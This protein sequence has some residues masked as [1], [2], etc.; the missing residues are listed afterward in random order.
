MLDRAGAT[1]AAFRGATLAVLA[2][3]GAAALGL[4]D[5]VGLAPPQAFL[6]A[7][8]AGALAGVL[9]AER[10]LRAAG[11]AVA[12]LLV[13][14]TALPLAPVLARGLVR[15]DRPAADS[16]ATV[17]AVAVLSGAVG[18]DGLV[19]GQ[20]LDRLLAGL[21][22]AQR[23]DRPIVVS[24]IHP[25][26]ARRVSTRADQ[27]RLAALAGLA[28]RLFTVDSVGTTHDEAV[29]MA[30]LAR[31]QGWRRVALV[32]SPAHTRRACATFER[33]GLPVVCT[34]AP[35]R[36]AAWGGPAPLRSS[37]DR[38]R[39]AANWMYETLGWALYWARGWV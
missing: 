16:G 35:A 8:A 10:A 4:P 23:T 17:D 32:T 31:A 18:D 9:G 6:G 2:W 33:A 21:A 5:L 36:D 22:L 39:A 15:R 37:A 34:P 11:A 14:V 19:Q 3:A 30:A 20:G 25:R 1:R 13:L 29:R 24:V 38:L 28:T 12:L 26:R 7:A 27:E